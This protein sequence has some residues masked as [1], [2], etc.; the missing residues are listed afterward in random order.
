M[1]PQ[2]QVFGQPE[3]LMMQRHVEAGGKHPAEYLL[4]VRHLTGLLYSGCG[5]LPQIGPHSPVQPHPDN[6]VLGVSIGNF[7]P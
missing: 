6:M 1:K 3:E 7:A 5:V 4:R 2:P